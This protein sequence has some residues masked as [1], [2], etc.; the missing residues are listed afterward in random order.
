[1]WLKTPRTTPK[2]MWVTPRMTDIFILKELRKLRWLTARLQTWGGKREGYHPGQPACLSLWGL[3]GICHPPAHCRAAEGNNG[4]DRQAGQ[5]GS[6][7]QLFPA[8][9][10]HMP[11]LSCIS[12]SLSVRQ[13]QR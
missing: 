3:I 12:V 13:E 2:V 10:R 6:R 1:M 7:P 9:Q 4:L 11:G 8:R 5:L